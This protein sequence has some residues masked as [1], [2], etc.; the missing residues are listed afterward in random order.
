MLDGEPDAG[1]HDLI[2]DW[3]DQI[4]RAPPEG[5][6]VLLP[7]LVGI[8]DLSAREYRTLDVVDAASFS[9]V[10]DPEDFQAQGGSTGTAGEADTP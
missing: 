4:V 3:G 7:R 1:L 9:P 6:T 10:D 5:I 8:D 2:L